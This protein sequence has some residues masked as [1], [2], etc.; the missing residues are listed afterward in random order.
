MLQTKTREVDGLEG[1]KL[2]VD[3]V[4]LPARRALKLAG[5]LGRILGPALAQTKGV[6]LDSDLLSLAPA[7]TALFSALTDADYDALLVEV[8]AMTTVTSKLDSDKVVRIELKGTAE[9][10]NVFGRDIGALVKAAAFVLEV[11]FGDF[12]GGVLRSRSSAQQ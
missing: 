7:L 10:D 8:F 12:I 4:T 5:K 1:R 11:N 3:T 6:S 2:Q 9:I